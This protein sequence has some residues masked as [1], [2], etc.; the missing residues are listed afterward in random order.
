MAT[1]ARDAVKRHAH[2]AQ[3]LGS[4]V[5]SFV[6]AVLGASASAQEPSATT[7][8]ELRPAL[9]LDETRDGPRTE[10]PAYSAGDATDPL[11]EN[12]TFSLQPTYERQSAGGSIGYMLLQPE[13]RFDIGPL[14]YMRFQWPVPQVN[15]G[16]GPTR[17]G[18]GDLQWLNLVGGPLPRE[19]GKLGVGPVFVFPAASSA[20]MG[21][22]KFQIGPALGYSNRAVRGWQFA[23]LLQ[24]FFSFAGD[25]DRATVNELKLQPFITKLLPDSWYVETKPTITLNFAKST[26]SVPLDLVVG[27]VVAGRWNLYLEATVYPGWTSPPSTDYRLTLNAGYLFPSPITGR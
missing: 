3:L 10:N 5:A 11:R 7:L 14:L 16:T 21:Q 9:T 8:G 6:F 20:Q 4:M 2:I 19:W 24:Q 18:V 22:G 12:W 15:D 17:A 27:K 13:L 1:P 25:A 23:F 26:S